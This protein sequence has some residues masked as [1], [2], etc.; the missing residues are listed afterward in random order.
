M[1]GSV[2]ET[3]LNDPDSWIEA[4]LVGSLKPHPRNYKTHPPDQIAELKA[5]IQK[6]TMYRNIVIARDDTILAGHGI[7]EAAEDMGLQTLP[8]KRLDLDPL[9]PR[10]LAILTAD[11]E[12]EHLADRDDRKLSELLKEINDSSEVTLEGTG[13]DER[14]LANLLYVTRPATEIKNQDAAAQWVGLP[15]YEPAAQVLKVVVNC[16]TPEDR[17]AFLEHIEV[18]S[19]SKTTHGTLS[20]WWP[21]RERESVTP[22]AFEE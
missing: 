8:A 4:V 15:D 7:A 20:I 19:V 12:L 16:E 18:T 14:M 2:I 6:N 5:S 21:L 3:W 17:D 22:L 9:E 11:N 10:A 1:E 13:Y